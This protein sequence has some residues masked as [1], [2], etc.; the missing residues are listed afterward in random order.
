MLNG[1]T[2]AE[3]ASGAR[4]GAANISREFL[5]TIRG[6]AYSAVT[7]TV[8]TSTLQAMPGYQA[9]SSPAVIRRR[10]IDYTVSATVCSLDDPKDGLGTTDA[11][12]CS[13]STPTSPA[14]NQPDDLKRVTVNVSWTGRR[15]GAIRMA[16]MLS[17]S[18]AVVGLPTQVFTMDSPTNIG[19][20]PSAPI[21]TNASTVV[22]PCAATTACFTASATGANKIIFAVDG[23]DQSGAP[24]TMDST[25][26]G[27]PCAKW[28]FAWNYA[29]VSDG[30]YRISARSVDAGGV[31]GTPKSILVTISRGGTSRPC[32]VGST[33]TSCLAVEGG[34]NYL[35]GG[36]STPI[37]ELR[38]QANPERNVIGYT[39][40]TGSGGPGTGTVVCSL[41][42]QGNVTS[43][44][45]Q[46]PASAP[47]LDQYACIDAS[48]PPLSSSPATYGVYAQYANAATGATV[49]GPVSTVSAV[50]GMPASTSY[51]TTTKTFGFDNRSSASG[52]TK[53]MTDG[54]NGSGTSVASASGPGTVTFCTPTMAT[55][56]PG[57]ASVAVQGPVSVDTTMELN[58]NAAGKDCTLLWALIHNGTTL[59]NNG[60]GVSFYGGSTKQTAI[61]NDA[62]TLTSTTIPA[63]ERLQLALTM[64]L[65]GSDCGNSDVLFGGDTTGV[66]GNPAPGRLQIDFRVGTTVPASLFAQPNPPTAVTKT[67]SGSNT[68]VSWT[69]SSGGHV[70]FY[71]IYRDGQLYTDRYDT[72][73]VG[74]LTSSGGCDNGNNTFTY[75]DGGTGGTAHSYSVT[76]VHS[77]ATTAPFPAT[78]AESAEVA[79]T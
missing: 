59:L 44:S 17:S 41:D 37:F 58:K 39:V 34:Y 15:A 13:A 47:G 23:T 42:G 67:A 24:V 28:H 75:T 69:G 10:N 46:S 64:A 63:A 74:D 32:G 36:G 60:T 56:F 18:G 77:P 33:P 40:Q 70:A 52:C 49:D 6:D 30:V 7:P 9:A 68:N 3:G 53:D 71:R 11:S 8:L 65:P 55:L 12:F 14:D 76:A 31:E 4:E 66:A 79:A 50:G 16:A 48:P 38:W 25:C 78:M 29:A 27:L 5:E 43:P 35:P 72:C 73:D 20:S 19:A 21:I 22:A 61:T 1:A 54:W 2:G 57:A 51:A 26:T 62:L 45:A